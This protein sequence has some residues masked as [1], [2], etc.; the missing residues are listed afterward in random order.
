V[1]FDAAAASGRRLERGGKCHKVYHAAT[2]AGIVVLTVRPYTEVDG[3][4]ALASKRL[5]SAGTTCLC[6]SDCLVWL[7]QVYTRIF[8]IFLFYSCLDFSVVFCLLR[9]ATIALLR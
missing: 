5:D 2:A 9:V 6:W 3:G 7:T 1:H 8:L 4:D